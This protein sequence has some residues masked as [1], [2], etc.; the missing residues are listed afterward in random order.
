MILAPMNSTTLSNYLKSEL[1]TIKGVRINLIDQYF[2][3]T[4]KLRIKY[5][6]E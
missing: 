3:K 6:K 2:V 1:I 4:K 5:C